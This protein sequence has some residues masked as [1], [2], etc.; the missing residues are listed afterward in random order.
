MESRASVSEDF[1]DIIA[2]RKVHPKLLAA[3]RK[4]KKLVEEL[5][6]KYAKDESSDSSSEKTVS[7]KEYLRHRNSFYDNSDTKSSITITSDGNS[8]GGGPRAP[9]VAFASNVFQFNNHSKSRR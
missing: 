6:S 7:S 8:L 4:K 2:S 5:E 9:K 1:D 3:Y